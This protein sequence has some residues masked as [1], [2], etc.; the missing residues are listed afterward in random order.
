MSKLPIDLVEF[1]KNVEAESLAALHY[2]HD[3][4]TKIPFALDIFR[5]L[6]GQEEKIRERVLS[7][8]NRDSGERCASPYQ[9]S[10]SSSFTAKPV[11]ESP[12]LIASD[13]SQIVPDKGNDVLFGLVNASGIVKGEQPVIR[14]IRTGGRLM[15]GENVFI[16]YHLMTDRDI[17]IIRDVFERSFLLTEGQAIKT[18]TNYRKDVKPLIGLFDGPIELFREGSESDRNPWFQQYLKTLH[19]IANE[20]IILGG[21]I[22][23][24]MAS[25]VTRMVE[26]MLMSETELGSAR[27]CRPLSG[28]HDAKM[29]DGLLKPGERSAVFKLESSSSH[30][31]DEQIS[32]HFFY[33]KVGY[34]RNS[35]IARVE[36]PRF[37]AEDENLVNLL[38]Y[39]IVCDVQPSIPYPYC[40]LRAHEIAVISTEMR[41][42]LEGIIRLTLMKKGIMANSISA[43]STAKRLLG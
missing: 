37:V 12:I 24:P 27:G 34:K 30:F 10:V 38:H 18:R 39:A 26:F 21:Y 15:M 11:S 5:S 6:A 3:V 8:I 14:E 4:Q 19:S 36:I 13:G 20:G 42:E 17:S 16:D 9:E 2:L 32:I 23:F 29:F 40:L 1:M 35:T 43:K 31:Y 33:L 25:P 28:V 7:V 22:D 41:K